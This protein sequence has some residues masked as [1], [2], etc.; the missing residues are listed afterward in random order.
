MVIA[1]KERR[2]FPRVNIKAPIRWQVSGTGEFNNATSNDIGLGGVGLTDDKFLAL[3]TRVNLEINLLSRIIHPVGRIVRVS[4]LPYSERYR[5]GV[6]FQEINPENKK[7][8][9]DYINMRLG[10]L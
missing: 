2:A 8:L 10:K 5:L 9:A 6:E 4:S 7:L 1:W 3:D